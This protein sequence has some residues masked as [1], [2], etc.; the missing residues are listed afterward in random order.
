MENKLN[1]AESVID[2]QGMQAAKSAVEFIN[3]QVLKA[4]IEN[5]G[6][7]A[8]PM[9]DQAAAMMIQDA[10][11]FLQGSEQMAMAA[12]GKAMTMVLS[13]NP[14]I[15]KAGKEAITSLEDLIKQLPDFTFNIGKVANEIT[16]G[17]FDKSSSSTSKSLNE[18]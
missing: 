8:K 1:K 7:S 9:A 2:S 17:K 12:L 14:V 18:I 6:S 16:T 10:R 15:Q 4:K 5:S 11:A 3:K 13:T